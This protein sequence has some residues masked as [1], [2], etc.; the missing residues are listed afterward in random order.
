MMPSEAAPP[1][2]QPNLPE[3]DD[4]YLLDVI[5]GSKKSTLHPTKPIVA[6]QAGCMI[7]VYDLLSDAKIQL[8]NHQHEV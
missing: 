3:Q 4:F 1:Q 8:S 2:T 5:G 7:I 6:Y